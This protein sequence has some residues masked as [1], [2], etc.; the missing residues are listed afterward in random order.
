ME[1]S[2]PSRNP[3]SINS[4]LNKD[5]KG[6]SIDKKLYRGMICS[7]LYLMASRPD[8]TFFVCLCAYFQSCTKES[9]LHIVKCI[10]KY[11]NGT[12]HLGLWYPR[13]ASFV[14]CSYSDADFAGSIL[15]KKSTLGTCQHLG[16]S[17]VSWCSKKQNSVALSIAKVEY[18]A[19][20]LY[21]SQVLWN[22]Q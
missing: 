11:L 1:N 3:M 2:K 5:K 16:H 6:K 4:K 12:L 10:L 9:H 13:N 18:V 20:N 17:L 22:K 21:C 15:D 19:V 8:I 14:L 7:L